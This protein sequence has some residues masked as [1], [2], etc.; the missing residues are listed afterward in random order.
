[1]SVLTPD[2]LAQ[3]HDWMDQ[4]RARKNYDLSVKRMTAT[5]RKMRKGGLSDLEIGIMIGHQLADRDM[6]GLYVALAV[7]AE[8]EDEVS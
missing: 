2:A 4:A 8:A 7:V 1:M 3:M 6:P 5:I